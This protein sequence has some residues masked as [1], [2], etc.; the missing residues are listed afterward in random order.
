MQQPSQHTARREI[1]ALFARNV[2]TTAFSVGKNVRVFFGAA[3]SSREAGRVDFLG[4]F[5]GIYT[6]VYV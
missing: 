6:T 3:K 4:F 1:D 2:E 5:A